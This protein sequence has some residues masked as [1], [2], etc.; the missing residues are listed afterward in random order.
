MRRQRNMTQ[1][2]EQYKTSEANKV[3]TSNLLDAEFKSLVI[4][5]LNELSE[6][7]SSIKKGQSEMKDILTE[8]KNNLQGINS[9][10]DEAKNQHTS[11]E[12]KEAKNTQ[13]EQQKEKYIKK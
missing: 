3:E 7:L 11:L 9:R 12:Y 2:E 13:S 4:R 8:M 5:M 6:N 1:T 10:V